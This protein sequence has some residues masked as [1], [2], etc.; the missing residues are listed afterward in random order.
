MRLVDLEP[1]FLRYEERLDTWT[2]VDR[3]PLPGESLSSIPHHQ[4]TGMRAYW[5]Y[6]Q[7]IDDA[8]GIEFLCPKCFQANGGTGGTHAVV[9]WSRSR[10]VPD[11]AQ[12]GPGRWQL[13]GTGYHDLTLE[14]EPGQ[15]R[16]VALIGGCTWHGFV[17]NGEAA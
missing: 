6:A 12:P 1:Q 10:G 5:P 8:Q 9:C 14:A 7:G 2:A 3:Q 15:S 11:A 17:T 16:S 13:V 4:V